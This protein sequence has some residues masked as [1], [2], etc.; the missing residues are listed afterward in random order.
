MTSELQSVNQSSEGP[1]PKAVLQK[2][3]YQLD[4]SMHPLIAKRRLSEIGEANALTTQE[5]AELRRALVERLSLIGSFANFPGL[6]KLALDALINTWSAHKTKESDTFAK[7]WSETEWKKQNPYI[8]FEDIQMGKMAPESL[9]VQGGN[10]VIVERYV[11][12]TDHMS[13]LV[14]AEKGEDAIG[15]AKT[16]GGI[17]NVV[18]SDGVSG[19][20]FSEIA[21]RTSVQ[22]SLR[23]LAAN[24]LSLDTFK[25][26]F[27]ALQEEDVP[28]MVEAILKDYRKQLENE[29][30]P[31]NKI[32]LSHGIKTLIELRDKGAL[33]AATLAIAQLD[34]KTG[35]L[36]LGVKGDSC[37]VV[38]KN[39]GTYTVY[40]SEGNPQIQ[41]FVNPKAN[42]SY[43]GD[44]EVIEHTTLQPQEVVVLC[45]DGVPDGQYGQSG[46]VFRDI[47]E[48]IKTARTQKDLGARVDFS[49][50]SFL[51]DQIAQKGVMDDVSLVV[52]ERI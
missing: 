18:V 26:A 21:S 41:Y 52:I 46:D 7:K 47:N 14:V 43:T 16:P 36:N 35:E 51:R 6:D 33:T 15:M 17:I 38:F 19:S 5:E 10:P 32:T 28:S 39:D 44:G 42:Y 27:D 45:T 2:Q 20:V 13:A 40:K 3:R 24:P 12:P 49:V 31:I 1:S 34:Q 50:T 29:A 9:K 25:V 30:D 8:R 23:Q 37:A 22:V 11:S 4:R 48:A